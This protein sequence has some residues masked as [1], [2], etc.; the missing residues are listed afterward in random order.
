MLLLGNVI[1]QSRNTQNRTLISYGAEGRIW[2][3]SSLSLSHNTLLSPGF[4]PGRF[5]RMHEQNLPAGFKLLAVNNVLAGLAV[6][7]WGNEGRFEGNV[8]TLGRW[9]R[10]PT[11]MDFALPSDSDQRS[12]AVDA[13]R[14]AAGEGRTL[15]PKYQFNLPIGKRELPAEGPLA[16]GALQ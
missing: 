8:H 2:P 4:V 9:L 12:A 15:R 10:G 5:L 14:F 6:F 3:G 7:E 16:P 11:A 13:A 1:G